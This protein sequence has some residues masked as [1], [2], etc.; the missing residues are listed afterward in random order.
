MSIS[1]N[2]GLGF[3]FGRRTKFGVS[4]LDQLDVSIWSYFHM[5]VVMKFEFELIIVYYF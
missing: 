1:H 3:S 4:Y 2:K 5:D